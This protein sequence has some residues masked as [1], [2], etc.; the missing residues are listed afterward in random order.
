MFFGRCALCSDFFSAF[1]CA[2][3]HESAK[4]SAQGAE[5]F[6][7]SINISIVRIVLALVL[8]AGFAPALTACGGDPPRKEWPAMQWRG[9]DTEPGS[10]PQA[11][12][13]HAYRSASTT[14]GR[15]AAF[16][17]GLAFIAGMPWLVIMLIPG[18]W[19][20]SL[21]MKAEAAIIL[22]VSG[23]IWY[24]GVA[25]HDLGLIW[26]LVWLNVIPGV[27]LAFWKTES[28]KIGLFGFFAGTA[29]AY[30]AVIAVNMLLSGLILQPLTTAAVIFAAVVLYRRVRSWE[31]LNS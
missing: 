2:L 21:E 26:W 30:I 6:M 31:V 5:V 13:D 27:I 10:R 16:T 1:A 20:G 29:A 17:I 23:M 7:D 28:G 3:T 11:V 22:A 4:K 25:F 9:S 19:F 8:I 24:L 18:I 14:V 15:H 12:A